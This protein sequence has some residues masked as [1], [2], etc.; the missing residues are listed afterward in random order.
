MSFKKEEK[1]R[2]GALQLKWMACGVKQSK[3]VPP[4]NPG[5]MPALPH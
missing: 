3:L 2:S 4:R 1:A 5:S